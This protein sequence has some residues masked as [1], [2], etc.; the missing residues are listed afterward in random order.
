MIMN[1]VF[2]EKEK[3]LLRIMTDI[4]DTAMTIMTRDPMTF[5][6]VI[7]LLNPL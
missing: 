1:R 3:I 4:Y 5:E 7:A 2:G 6:N